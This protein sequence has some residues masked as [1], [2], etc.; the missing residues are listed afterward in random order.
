MCLL[1]LS[2]ILLPYAHA[3]SPIHLRVKSAI[4]MNMNDGKILFTYNPDEPIQPASLTKVLALYLVYESLNQGTAHMN[5]MVNISQTA[6]R[7]GGSRMCLKA[8]KQIPLEELMKGMA[9]VSGNDA[10][11]AVAEHFG[12]VQQFVDK[13]NL[14]A[15]QLGMT[16]SFFLNPNGLPAD[17]QVTT[18]RDVLTLSCQYLTRFPEA[19]SIHSMRYL[20]YGKSQRPN[21]NR[22]LMSCQ[23]VDGLKTGYVTSAGFHIIATAKR[24]DVRLIA[25]VMG[26]RN[27]AV[28]NRE[29][30]RLLD[31][32]F[33]MVGQAEPAVHKIQARKSNGVL[34][35]AS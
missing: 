13:M 25:V 27:T 8:G 10:S 15:R 29:T 11:V 3:S 31:E 20:T 18:A 12:G 35:H 6:W 9:I 33:K 23:D 4:M 30:R 2:V 24:G 1:I 26:A 28:R 34:R 7:T 22:L 21:H 16:H 17:G 14:K 19:L 5:D 32:G